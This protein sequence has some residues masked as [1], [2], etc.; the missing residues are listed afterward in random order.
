MPS[1]HAIRDVVLLSALCWALYLPG[2]TAHGLMNWQEGQRALVAR[3]MQARGEWLVPTAHG[4][5]YLAKP[6]MIYWC[7]LGLAELRGARCG[8]F[9]LRATVALFGWGA[10]GCAVGRGVSGDG[11]AV[12]AL[13][14]GW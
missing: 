12:C 8:E 9:E 7:E 4:R 6:P 14:P 13:K 5:P 1:R 2:L 10:G 3:E 11:P